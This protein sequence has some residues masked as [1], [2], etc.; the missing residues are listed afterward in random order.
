MRMSDGD[1]IFA[2][3]RFS[4]CSAVT[5]RRGRLTLSVAVAV[6][7]LSPSAL[8]RLQGLVD[9]AVGLLQGVLRRHL[10]AQRRVDV[11]VDGRGDLRVDRRHGPRLRLRDGL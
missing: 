9:L 8:E 1:T 11:L 4:A 5:L 2:A 10:T 6:A 3:S 7:M